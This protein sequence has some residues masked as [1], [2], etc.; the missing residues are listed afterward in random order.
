MLKSH[1]IK[2]PRVENGYDEQNSYY[3]ILCNVARFSD[4]GSW[5]A[6]SDCYEPCENDGTPNYAIRNEETVTVKK[7]KR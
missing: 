3:K 7:E 5:G 4:R 1:D 6:E 2:C